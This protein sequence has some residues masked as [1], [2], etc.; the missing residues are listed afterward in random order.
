MKEKNAE[1]LKAHIAAT[2]AYLSSPAMK[3]FADL[4]HSKAGTVLAMLQD[5][6]ISR[7]KACEVLALLAHGVDWDDIPLPV[8][9][10]LQ[11]GEDEVPADVV[12]AL[13]ASMR[14]I[15]SGEK[16]LVMF[17]SLGC[18]T[19]DCDHWNDSTCSMKDPFCRIGR[20]IDATPER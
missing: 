16:S 10:G 17:G 3:T 18:L 11:F 12:E 8:E 4:K 5:G 7:G 15:A 20:T 19:D 14:Q 13:K 6:A 1:L 9:S 2:K